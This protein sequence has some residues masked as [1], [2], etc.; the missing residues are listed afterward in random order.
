[1]WPLFLA[2]MTAGEV[3]LEVPNGRPENVT[4]P[5]RSLIRTIPAVALAAVVALTIA[6]CGSDSDDD[7]GT[8]TTATTG[9]DQIVTGSAKCNQAELAKAVQGWG[10]SQKTRA[11]LPADPV[12]YQC[13]DGWAVAFPNVGPAAEEVTITLVFE[14]E[15]QFWVEKDRGK[16]C[17]KDSP[18][19]QKLYK[20][21]CQTN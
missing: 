16:V 2:R 11:Q 17:G 4:R 7:S 10:E 19:P 8:T 1:M 20:A 12:S 5:S 15:G 18:V 3:R 6:A 14:A 21:A 13:A 9:S